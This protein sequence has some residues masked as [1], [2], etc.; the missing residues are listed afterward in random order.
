LPHYRIAP[1]VKRRAGKLF[2]TISTSEFPHW[3]NEE[4]WRK[5]HFKLVTS[6]TFE[7]SF[8]QNK[9][10]SSATQP[11]GDSSQSSLRGELKASRPLNKTLITY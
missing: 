10:V 8:P 3:K 6:F 7:L 9:P 4:S 11:S 5:T 2:D 1:D